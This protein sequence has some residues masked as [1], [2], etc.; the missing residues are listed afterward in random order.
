MSREE[1]TGWRD[2]EY[3][4]RHRCFGRRLYM[5]DIDDIEG[6]G[7]KPCGIIDIKTEV[8][9]INEYSDKLYRNLAE[10]RPL[11]YFR[12]I[13]RLDFSD[14][15]IQPRNELGR[16]W[17]PNIE[18]VDEKRYIEFLSDLRGINLDE[19]V[20]TGEY[21]IE[22][23]KRLIELIPKLEANLARFK[24]RAIAMEIEIFKRSPL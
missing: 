3:S 6:D 14:Y 4:L 21:I 10:G 18:I 22:Y 13:R 15:E 12:V 19:K 24:A 7:D 1:R 20:L 2:I 9:E 16:K 8:A 17:I 23:H 11:P 5:V